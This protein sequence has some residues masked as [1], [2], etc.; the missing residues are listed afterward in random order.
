MLLFPPGDPQI[1]ELSKIVETE[2]ADGFPNG[3]PRS[4]TKCFGKY[5]DK[6]ED[7][8][9]YYDPKYK[10][11]YVLTCSA[12]EDDFDP[13]K[14][15]I[16]SNYQPPTSSSDIWP[17]RVV[18]VNLGITPFTKGKK[19][20]GGWLNGVMLTDEESPTGRLDNKPTVEQMFSGL[21]EKTP[22]SFDEKSPPNFG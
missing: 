5:S 10:D 13:Q 11:W 12:K 2:I 21:G 19:G 15:I 16:D 6:I 22:P 14:Q 4:S 18:W 7:T 17:G 1:A 8:K 3:F 9:D 20:I